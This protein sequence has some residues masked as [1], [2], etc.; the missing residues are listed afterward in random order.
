MYESRVVM[1]DYVLIKRLSELNFA[2]GNINLGK[3]I[4]LV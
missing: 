4:L 3:E 1:N 2:K